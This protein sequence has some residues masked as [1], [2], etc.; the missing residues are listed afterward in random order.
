MLNPFVTIKELKAKID[1][2]EVSSNEVLRF[3]LD[4]IKKHNPKLNAVLESFDDTS[5]QNNS[6][7][8]LLGGI[9]YILKDNILQ[10]GK[11]ATAGSN[12]LS[13]YKAPYDSTVNHRLKNAG[14]ISIGRANCDEFAMSA[15]GETSAFGPTSNPW[16]ESRVPGGSSSGSAAAVAAGFAPF[17]LGTETGGSVRQPSSYCN[18]VGLYPTYGLH[19]RYGV[20]AFAS[21]F[22]QV[23]AMTHTVYD[24]ALVATALSG[25]D[26]KDSTS[27]KMQPKDYTKNLDGK[28]PENFTVGVIKDALESDGINPEVSLAFNQAIEQLKKLG[29][30][31]KVVDL[32]HLK[33]GNAVYFIISR[34]EA[35]SNM[36]R[37][38]GSLYG[39]RIESSENL[40]DMYLKTR[41]RGFGREVKL[42]IMTGN[43]VLSVGHKDAYYN[44]A[45]VV[46][47]II[48]NEFESAFKDVD[49]L[50]S[51]TSSMLP[52]KIG[53]LAS[54]P[55][56]MYLGDLFTVPNC[57]IGTPGLSL[58]CG[59]SKNDLPIGFQFLGPRLSEELL[60]KIGYA[61]EQSTDYHLR[62]PR[63][64]E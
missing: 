4:R 46:R 2:K 12:I 53:E 18:L 3:Y 6:T 7:D 42:R 11:T 1:K 13:N 61:F 17:A 59:F 63:N 58:P 39:K 32:P 49:L 33:Y 44:K 38:D 24:N 16:D 54:D 62:H 22:D 15:S 57:V 8:G 26:L 43:Y 37:Y 50:I 21:S 47:S 27:I 31:V 36:A 25:Q 41:E 56:A 14:G 19:S 40:F 23:G 29:A 35:A 52:F 45:Q 55:I 9:P 51:P 34:A 10:Q 28:L 30:K 64:Y 60:F 48:R 20:M 5:A